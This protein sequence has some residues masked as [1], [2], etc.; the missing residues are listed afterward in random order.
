MRTSLS[1][2]HAADSPTCKPTQ[3]HSEWELSAVPPS[4]LA[5][6]AQLPVFRP[7]SGPPPCTLTASQ[8]GLG[9]L[10][11]GGRGRNKHNVRWK[12]KC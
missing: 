11:P 5:S 1:T 8:P 12:V 10:K 3:L 6:S 7:G 9:P 4:G 2:S